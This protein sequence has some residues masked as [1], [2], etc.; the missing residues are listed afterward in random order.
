MGQQATVSFADRLDRHGDRIAVITADET[1]TYAELEDRVR[2]VAAQLGR[3]RRLVL[4]EARNAAAPLVAYLAALRGGHPVL[5]VPGDSPEAREALAAAY[6]P[7]VYVLAET[8]WAVDGRRRESTHELHPDLALLLST[9]GSTGSAKV[10]RLSPRNLQANAGAIAQYLGIT[11][12][13]RAITTLP[14]Q[15]CYGLSVINSHLTCGAA[16]VLT[17]LS[18]VDSCFWQLFHSSGATSFAGVPH[19]FDLLDRVGFETMALPNLRYVTQAGGRLDPDKVRAYAALG[20]RNGWQLFVMYGQTEATARMAYLPPRL[21]TSHP[22]AIGVAIPG[23]A[24]SIVPVDEHPCRDGVGELVYEGPNVM[25]GYADGPADLALGA[26]V[27]ALHTGDLAR[28][29]ADGLYEVVGRRSRFLKLHGVRIDLDRVQQLLAEGGTQ[30]MCT[31]DDERLVVALSDGAG[32]D[33]ATRLLERRLRLPRARMRIVTF[34]ELPRLPNGK[35]DY[36]AIL[37][38]AQEPASSPHGTDAVDRRRAVRAAFVEILGREPSDE[39][40]FVSL[41]GDSLS[42]VEMSICLEEILGTLPRD[43]PTTPV[44]ELIRTDGGPRRTLRHTETSVVLRAAA[45]LLIVATHTRLWYLPGGA[46]TLLAIAGYNFARFQLA[47]RT[48]LTTVLRIAVPSMCWIGLV[49][50]TTD[51]FE[52]S[53]ALL[54]NGH[55]GPAGARWSYWYIE[56]IVQILAA[57]ALLF[58]IP[59]SVGMERRRPF[60]FALGAVAVGL[61]LRPH[62][63]GLLSADHATSRPHAVFW[64]FALGWAIARADTPVRRAIVSALVV[65]TVPGFFGAPSRELVVIVGLLLLAWVPTIV[66]P[67]ALNRAV[68]V[69]AAS[70]LY[71]YLTHWQF[72]PPV[73]RQHG[74]LAA[75]TVSVLAGIGVAVAGRR[76]SRAAPG[77]I[78]KRIPS[79]ADAMRFRPQIAPPG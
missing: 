32:A 12:A 26:T 13:D 10:V 15:Y 7:D 78:R 19:T 11:P 16:L 33:S 23:G 71:I 40:S 77:A 9:S 22:N 55:L 2:S 72:Y 4:L 20:E 61:V 1:I 50:A 34:D 45:I 56:A 66:L 75:F 29:S 68:G 59:G 58:A 65:A 79:I 69:V 25:L 48:R 21:A 42:Y 8:G 52:W 14:M 27:G 46:H 73:L 31:G 17:E 38:R 47:A 3:A 54:L 62:L 24:F 49:A 18:V 51:G 5:L 36:V 57:L 43:W 53:H 70:S 63:L 35:P 64:L 41:D 39:D 67:A 37:A 6:D 30:S 44:G 60:G 74:A 76:L 28:Q